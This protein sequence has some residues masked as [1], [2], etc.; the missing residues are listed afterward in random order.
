MKLNNCFF[1]DIETCLITTRSGR[2]KPLHI[3]DWSFNDEV[4]AFII[5]SE[6]DSICLV[7]DRPP[8]SISNKRQY[9]KLIEFV[10][11]QMQKIVKRGVN[12]MYYNIKDAYLNYPCPGGFFNY[13]VENDVDVSISLYLTEN[14]KSAELSGV[15][16]IVDLSYMILHG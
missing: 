2:E 6:Y 1:I 10:R 5:N 14:T 16:N 3:A 9:E 13:Y 7:A 12:V 11:E 4:L 8:S 15:K